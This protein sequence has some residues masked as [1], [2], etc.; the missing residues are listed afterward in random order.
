MTEHHAAIR[1]ENPGTTLAHDSFSRDHRWILKDGRVTVP[2]SAAPSFRGSDGAVDPEEALVAALASCH[3]LTFL[4][5]AAKRRLVV[6][7]YADDAVG[8][9]EPDAAGRLAITRVTLRPVVT[10]GPDSTPGPA[11]LA[12]LHA[13]AHEH[14]FIANSVR[15]TV[16]VEPAPAASG[17]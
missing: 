14:C 1:W 12:K 16:V 11:E 15:A 10:F 5:I 13:K 2:A 3:M 7:G 4:A 9:L 17:S 6:T 8:V